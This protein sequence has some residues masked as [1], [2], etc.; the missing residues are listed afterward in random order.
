[1][2]VR[3]ID[4]SKIA[5]PHTD[6]VLIYHTLLFFWTPWEIYTTSLIRSAVAMY[7]AQPSSSSFL[8]DRFLD[9][10]AIKQRQ[11]VKLYL[12][13]CID[14]YKSVFSELHVELKELLVFSF[15]S[16]FCVSDKKLSIS[17][18]RQSI[19]LEPTFCGWL[20]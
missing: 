8:W 17:M 1:M 10:M 18:A 3:T 5:Q 7:V 20:S 12:F 4:S 13:V 2:F 11:Y 14:K 16:N 6:V 15:S 9:L 19:Q